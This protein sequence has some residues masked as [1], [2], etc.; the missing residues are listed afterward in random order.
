MRCNRLFPEETAGDAEMGLLCL[1]F[2]LAFLRAVISNEDPSDSCKDFGQA[3]ERMFA[4]PGESPLLECP[5]Q[6]QYLFDTAET[7]YNVTWLEGRNGSEVTEGQPSVVVREQSLWFP[8]ISMEQQG[9]YTCVV[10]TPSRC[11]RQTAVLVVSE[12]TSGRCERPQWV[13]QQ[14]S[15]RVNDV[16]SCPLRRYLKSVD[17]PSIQ[18]YKNCEPLP[19]DEKFA[20][21]T[22]KDMLN[23]RKVHLDDAGFY[24]CKMTFSLDGVVGE[25][26]ESIECLV[27]DEYL[28]KPR[29]IEPADEIIR[30]E[31]EFSF[32]FLAQIS[33]GGGASSGVFSLAT[34]FLIDSFYLTWK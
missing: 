18:W 7:P 21:N 1:V 8:N 22:D 27:H 2:L 29:V 13:I 28:E 17:H 23:I 32:V 5:L 10:R 15:A 16:L 19:E 34:E 26:A 31:S 24:T 30:V 3:F 33:H 20:L 6:I 11:F 14:I 9:T 12:M 25:M 4:V